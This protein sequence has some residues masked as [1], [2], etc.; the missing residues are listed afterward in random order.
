M[1]LLAT[2]APGS[3]EPDASS[4]HSPLCAKEAASA[5]YAQEI[6]S[7]FGWIPYTEARRAMS[8][9]LSVLKQRVSVF[10]SQSQPSWGTEIT[11]PLFFFSRRPTVEND[12][13]PCS[14]PYTWGRIALSA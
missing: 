5:N 11:Y 2:G 3:T 14:S 6:P 7:Q 12:C 4:A 9:F 10:L 13:L 1:F 8:A